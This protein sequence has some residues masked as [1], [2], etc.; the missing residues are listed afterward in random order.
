MQR[1]AAIVSALTIASLASGCAETLARNTTR[2]AVAGVKEAGNP[3]EMVQHATRAGTSG[4]LEALTAEERREALTGL[5]HDVTNAAVRGIRSQ[6]SESIASGERPLVEAVGRLSQSVLPPECAQAADRNACARAVLRN[7][8]RTTASEVMRAFREQL[9]IAPLV[10][11][12]VAGALFALFVVF[13]VTMLR[14]RRHI[15]VHHAQPA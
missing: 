13:V 15:V 1:A 12:F 10:A 11:A 3:A 4:A 9:G 5:T 8:T 7:V 6:L 14:M 2:G